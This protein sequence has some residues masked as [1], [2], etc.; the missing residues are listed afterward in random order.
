MKTIN[1]GS[2]TSIKDLDYFIKDFIEALL[3]VKCRYI[4]YQLRGKKDE[5]ELEMQKQ[6]KRVFAY[7]FYHQFR[8][9]MESKPDKYEGIYLNGEAHKGDSIYSKVPNSMPD[10]ILNKDPGNIVN[11]GQFFLCEMKTAANAQFYKDFDKLYKF[12]ESGLNFKEYIF[13]SIGETIEDLKAKIRKNATKL[14][15]YD[16]ETLCLCINLGGNEVGYAR[17]SE[18]LDK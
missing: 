15:K 16:K 14:T 5:N 8:E 2:L 3:N 4:L 12:K 7:E 1:K 10:I 9:L 6:Y 17:L 13:L 18:L 11:D